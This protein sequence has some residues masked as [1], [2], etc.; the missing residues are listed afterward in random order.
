MKPTHRFVVTSLSSEN[1]EPQR[2]YEEIYCARGDI[3]LAHSPIL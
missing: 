2:L 3:S 1:A